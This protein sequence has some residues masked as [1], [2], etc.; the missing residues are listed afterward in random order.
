M[1][2]TIY[3]K[4]GGVYTQVGDYRLPNLIPGSEE[5]NVGPWG[6]RHLRWLRKHRRVTYTNLLT[7]GKLPAYLA[8][9]DREAQEMFSLLTAQYAAAE[10]VTEDL[11][12]DDQM[13]WVGRMNNIRERVEEVVMSELV[14]C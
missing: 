3:E 13:A 4:S 14:Y 11:K 5:H 10:G 12:A 7:T 8:D 6:L 2:N 9:I 1:K